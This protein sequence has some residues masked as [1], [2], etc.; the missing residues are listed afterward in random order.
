MPILNVLV[1]L[2]TIVCAVLVAYLG[3]WGLSTG[4]P[5]A[6][7]GAGACLVIAILGVLLL[8]RLIPA[9]RTDGSQHTSH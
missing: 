4:G 6:L 1:L 2:V 3:G 7:A 5:A 8:T 9:S